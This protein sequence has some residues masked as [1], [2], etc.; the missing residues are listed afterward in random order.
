MEYKSRKF[1]QVIILALVFCLVTVCNSSAYE[2]EIKKLSS[3]MAEKIAATKKAKV[4]VVDFTDLQGDVTELG[5]FIA[6][7]FSVAL[8]SAGKGFKVVDRTHLKTIH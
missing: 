2:A 5:R 6:E 1:K 3:T 4:A 7:E 8:A